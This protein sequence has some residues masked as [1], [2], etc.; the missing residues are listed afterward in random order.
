[1]RR[2]IKTSV[3]GLA[4]YGFTPELARKID[5]GLALSLK[6]EPENIHDE[7]A[8][9][10]YAVGVKIGHIRRA[11]A[12]QIAGAIR[13]GSRI[14]INLSANTAQGGDGYFPVDVSVEGDSEVDGRPRVAD[15]KVAGIYRIT[16]STMGYYYI[17]QSLDVNAR[18]K[19]HFGSLSLG[20][21]SNSGLQR[22]WTDLGGDDFFAD[23]VEA[24]PAGLV[25]VERQLWLSDKEK[26]YIELGKK[27]GLCVNKYPGGLVLTQELR[28]LESEDARQSRK[29]KNAAI[30]QR[31][32]EINKELERLEIIVAEV[33]AHRLKHEAEVAQIRGEIKRKTGLMSILNGGMPKTER[34]TKEARI[35]TLQGLMKKLDG[36]L[37]SLRDKREA[38][39]VE[40]GGLKLEVFD[41][42]K[43]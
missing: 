37:K 26:F 5:S 14:S 25:G 15:G 16:C 20:V 24:A 8:V 31:K 4:Y 13:V 28:D 33:S 36:E 38:L 30:T 3:V 6:A 12:A 19:E 21:H 39:S 18:I 10:V 43:A 23:L 42:S 27:S 17:G 40:L 41:V 11:E 32:L 29:E 1:M 22:V 7:N 34:I 35:Y 2:S 9:A